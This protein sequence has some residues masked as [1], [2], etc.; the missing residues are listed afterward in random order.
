MTLRTKTKI[1]IYFLLILHS[2]CEVGMRTHPVAGGWRC[3]LV[4]EDISTS[5]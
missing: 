5:L 4:P 1:Q 2:G 3:A